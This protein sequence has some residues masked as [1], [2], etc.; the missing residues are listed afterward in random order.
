MIDQNLSY[1]IVK[2]LPSVETYRHLR[3]AAGLSAKNHEAAL[4]GLPNSLFAV[5][6]CFDDEVIGMGRI[7]GDG[8]T[9]FQVVDIAVVPAHQGRGVGKM[10]MAE[11]VAFIESDVPESGYVSLLADGQANKLYAQFGFRPTAPES[12]GM[13]YKKT[14]N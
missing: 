3:L 4:R 13:S 2:A 6:I 14:A 5:Q 7:V 9:F 12:I 10:I 11:I 8:G 1:T